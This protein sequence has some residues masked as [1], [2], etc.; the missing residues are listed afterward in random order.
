MAFK[1]LVWPILIVFLAGLL[2]AGCGGGQKA[3]QGEKPQA[4]K[5][6][7]EK[8][9]AEKYPTRP[10]K[11]MVTH[12]PGSTTDIATRLMV[13]YLSKNLGQPVV[14]ENLEGGGGRVARAQVF[15]EKAD[16][17]TLLA[18]GFPS[19]QLGE[20]LYKGAYKTAEW[21]YLYNFQGGGDYGT[22][23]VAKD[24][25]YQSLKDLVEAS[26][27]KPLTL[28]MAGLGS[29]THLMSS[30]MREK[31][32]LQHQIVPFDAAQ[33]VMAVLGKQVDAALDSASGIATEGRVRLLSVLSDHGRSALAPDVPS[34]AEQGYPGMEVSFRIGLVG[35]PGMPEEVV[36]VLSEAMKKATSDPALAADYQ[37]AKMALDPLAPGDFKKA[38][39]DLLAA[40]QAVVPTMEKEMKTIGTK[41]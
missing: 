9:K 41:Q 20:L 11:I 5:S 37:K 33:V 19:T 1:R 25:P 27:K 6:Q 15:K 38:N 28:G 10:V 4:E 22:I 14:V 21:T 13:P 12:G 16:G 35:P 18:T 31:A 7:T 36:K 2:L 26:K 32:G 17:Y 8:P 34:T 39:Q 29:G 30:L 23:Y 40:L 24:S 3:S